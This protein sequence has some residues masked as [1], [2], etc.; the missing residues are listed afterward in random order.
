[1]NGKNELVGLNSWLVVVGFGVV[2]RP[3]IWV[4]RPIAFIA[5]LSMLKVGRSFQI[6][7][8]LVFKAD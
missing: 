8:R 4:Y 5:K 7:L 3:F 6:L 1:M 2:L